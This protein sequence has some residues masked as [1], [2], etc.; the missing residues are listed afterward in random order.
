MNR[1]TPIPPTY[2]WVDLPVGPQPIPSWIK[3]ARVSWMDGYG[4]SPSLELLTT[5]RPDLW[6]GKRWRRHPGDLYAAVSEDGRGAFLSASG[7]PRLEWLP[8]KLP[9]ALPITNPVNPYMGSTFWGLKRVWATPQSEGFAG[10]HFDIVIEDGAV[11]G[12]LL[13]AAE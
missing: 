9:L 10:R 3:G 7:E 12:G 4:N 8:E 2:E 5:P 13:A 1:H 6:E 11:A